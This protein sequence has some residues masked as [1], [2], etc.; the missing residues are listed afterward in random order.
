[1]VTPKPSGD[2]EKVVSK[3]PSQLRQELKVRAAQVG[4]DIQDAVSQGID[5]WQASGQE[6][7]TVDTTGGVAWSSWLPPGQWSELKQTCAERGIP[8]VQGL[9]QAIELWLREHSAP[10][11][12]AYVR[13]IVMCNQKGGVGK[14]AIATGFAGACAEDSALQ[15]P[16][17]AE[18]VALQS[19]DEVADSDLPG[20][21]E[22]LLKKDEI[23]PGLGLRVLLVDYDP[24]GH[25]TKQLGVPAI[26]IDD[27]SLAKYMA[28]TV[29]TGSVRDLIVKLEDKHFG[30]RLDVLPACAD[31][32]L[33]D[34]MISTDRN[35]QAT[36]ER[37]LEPLEADYDVIVV[38]CPPSL[39]VGMD[40]AIYYGRRREDEAPGNS[41]VLIPVQAEDSSADAFTLLLDQIES[42]Q[43]DWRIRVD[44][45]G[46]VVNLYDAR[47]GYVVTS[48]LEAWKVQKEPRVV[49]VIGRLKEQREAVRNKRALVAYA[50]TSQQAKVIRRIA[51]EIV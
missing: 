35:R 23:H 31:A 11:L 13:R 3:L 41:G 37:A 22:E 50:P 8:L 29:R 44:H 48:A 15:V 19:D 26:G 28:G 7:P 6:H 12:Q 39:G 10:P 2:R 47:D 51:R 45:L 25:L 36:L 49:G 32:F 34:I 42:G 9:A 27:P 40:A 33:L 4:V 43:T 5:L 46:L 20:E 21:A 16:V 1:M 24:Q 38:D 18:A 30:G 17:A 14:T